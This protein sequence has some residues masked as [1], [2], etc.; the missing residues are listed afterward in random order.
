MCLPFLPL[1]RRLEEAVA[2][3]EKE[4]QSLLVELEHEISVTVGLL[5]TLCTRAIASHVARLKAAGRTKLITPE[6]SRYSRTCLPMTVH[7]YT[8]ASRHCTPAIAKRSP[9]RSPPL[10][11]RLVAHSGAEDM[12]F[13][14]CS[15][16][17]RFIEHGRPSIP[18]EASY[19]REG[20]CGHKSKASRSGGH[21]A[22]V[23]AAGRAG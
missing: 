2:K 10:L 8:S 22:P 3:Q 17:F 13:F 21:A 1:R 4:W 14:A 16:L 11:M 20:V 12:F 9:P 15:R 6:C 23:Y 18:I 7:L 19:H 5:G